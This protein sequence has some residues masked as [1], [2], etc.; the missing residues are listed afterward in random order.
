MTEQT[1]FTWDKELEQTA[2]VADQ[3]GVYSTVTLH[4]LMVAI[5]SCK[6]KF[7]DADVHA[8]KSF[9]GE[10][11]LRRSSL[12]RENFLSHSQGGLSTSLPVKRVTQTS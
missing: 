6:D 1:L 12:F 4:E 7:D 3:E 2:L 5:L 8:L 11:A 10:L 9:V